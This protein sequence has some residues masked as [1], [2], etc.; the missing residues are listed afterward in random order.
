[1]PHDFPRPRS[2]RHLPAH[3]RDLYA[4]RAAG[5][6]LDGAAGRCL[7]SGP[8]RHGATDCR[9]RQRPRGGIRAGRL[10]ALSRLGLAA[11]DLGRR[12]RLAHAARRRAGPPAR[13]GRGLQPRRRVLPGA[14]PALRPRHLARLLGCRHGPA[15]RS[16]RL[17]VVSV[18]SRWPNGA[19]SPIARLASSGPRGHVAKSG[20]RGGRP[21][22]GL[23]SALVY[24]VPRHRARTL[25]G[26]CHKVACEGRRDRRRGGRMQRALPPD[27][28]GLEGRGS[29]RAQRAHLGSTWHAAGGMHTLNSDPNVAKL[30]DYTVR[31]YQ[32]IEALSGQSCGI[33]LTGGVMLAGTPA[34]LDY[35]RM[36]HARGRYLGMKTEIISAD[37]AQRLFPLLDKRHFVGALYD[38]VEG[39]IDPTG[40][41][42][43]YAKSARLGG[44]E[45]Y[46]FTR[47]TDLQPRP[48]G[49]W[50]VVTDNGTIRVEHVVNAGGLWA[51]EV[52]R[53]V[54]LELPVLA[55]EHQY[56][57]TEDIPEVAA[58]DEELIHA[59]DFEG[60]LYL[61]QEG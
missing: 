12:P 19:A 17:P 46:R 48:D 6:Q 60:E 40:V 34:R 36:T 20:K 15:F 3:R 26:G 43:A 41:T 50:D 11:A 23:P 24:V 54:G 55:M 13:R 22:D 1:R 7:G 29:A 35:L 38:P 32:E 49:S 51:R 57:L 45:I 52:G 31:P 8:L 56:L 59:I 27:Q 25:R 14:A 58:R 9:V 2:L 39:H 61:R 30:Q 33:H 21:T 47:V 4:L 16:G 53:M 28:A 18:P 37:E 5:A 44:A 10:L 42:Q